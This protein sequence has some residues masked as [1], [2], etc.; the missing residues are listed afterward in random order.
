MPSIIIF[1]DKI[2][3]SKKSFIKYFFISL[4][5][6]IHSSAITPAEK[7]KIIASE[8][9]ELEAFANKR[10]LTMKEWMSFVDR[11]DQKCE[12]ETEKNKLEA[13]CSFYYDI[14]TIGDLFSEKN[15]AE[16]S[17]GCSEIE[18]T[19]KIQSSSDQIFL[20]VQKVLRLLCPQK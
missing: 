18:N 12:N 7:N 6:I 16:F 9:T 11:V 19:A 8:L 4:F 5:F 14:S 2:I 15:S 10:S 17:K 3:N 1:L 20:N 13:Y